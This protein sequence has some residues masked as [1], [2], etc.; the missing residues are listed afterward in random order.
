MAGLVPAIHVFLGDTAKSWMHGT[1]SAKTR[2]ALLPGH[3][4]LNGKAGFCCTTLES[5]SEERRLATTPAFACGK[6]TDGV[7]RPHRL[8]CYNI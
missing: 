1:S 8:T 6:V 7:T 5:S 3:D 2:F 4:E